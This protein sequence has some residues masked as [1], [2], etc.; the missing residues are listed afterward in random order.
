MKLAVF[1]DVHG[2]RPALEAV[3]DDIER[4][5]PDRVVLNGDLVNRGPLS[6]EC[7]R[8]VQR[9]AAEARLI[10]GNH[11]N[12]VLTAADEPRDPEDPTFELRRMAHWTH[13][14]L[15]EAIVDLQGWRDHVDLSDPE[16]R[17]SVHVTHGSRRGDRDGI[18]PDIPD[19]ELGDK[20]GD[21]PDLFIASHTHTPL[22]RRFDGALVVNTGSVGQPFDGDP[23]AAYGR[24]EWRAGQW[25]A[26]IARVE[27]DRVKALRDFEESGFLDGAG[28]L[29]Q[30]IFREVAECRILV[31]P[32]MR[33]YRRQV[34]AGAI[35][36]AEAVEEYLR[37][38]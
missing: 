12:F 34:E 1:S 36:V 20:L 13:D 16:G 30:V 2:N 5:A 14:Q 15:G 7:L 8:L 29:A 33:R 17:S 24:F 31:G 32:W 23:R 28:P 27:F 3:L 37:S 19:E 6:L 21:L 22:V 25:H 35:T 4:W 38:L 26:R 18:R 9:R 10:G 11:E